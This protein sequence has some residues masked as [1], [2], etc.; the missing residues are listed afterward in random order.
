MASIRAWGEVV[1]L[2]GLNQNRSSAQ[3]AEIVAKLWQKCEARVA[4]T[5]EGYVGDFVQAYMRIAKNK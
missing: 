3:R 5:P 4:K 1:F 2:A